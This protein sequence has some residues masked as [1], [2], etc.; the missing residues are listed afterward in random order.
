MPSVRINRA[1]T[2]L[3]MPVIPQAIIDERATAPD[4]KRLLVPVDVQALYVEEGSEDLFV[5][6]PFE[7]AGSGDRPPP[8]P[9]PF[10]AGERR[11]AGVHLRWVPPDALLRGEISEASGDEEELRLPLLPDRWVVLRILAPVGETKPALTGWVLEAESARAVPLAQWP[12]E[13]ARFEPQGRQVDSAEFD[14]TAGGSPAWTA[15]YDAA[16]NRFSFHDPLDDLDAVAPGGVTGGLAAYLVAGWY[17]DPAHDPLDPSRSPEPLYELLDELGWTVEEELGGIPRAQPP[18]SSLLHGQVHGVPVSGEAVADL[19][20]IPDGAGAELALAQDDVEAVAAL[21]ASGL[22]GE[23]DERRA[24]ERVLAA[25]VSG[26]LLRL[27]TPDGLVDIE[28]REHAAGFAARPG[29]SGPRER[30]LPA[31]EAGPLPAGR[32]ARSLAQD[33]AAAPELAGGERN[34][35]RPAPRFQQPIEPL[36]AVR[37]PK[38]SLIAHGDGRFSADGKLLCRWPSQVA[39]GSD[40]L[41]GEKLIGD[42]GASSIPEEVL[43]LARNVLIQDPFWTEWLAAAAAGGTPETTPHPLVDRLAAEAVL[44]FGPQGILDLSAL[45]N[46]KPGIEGVV[47]P[48][49]EADPVG[50][51]VWSQPWIPLFLEWE[52]EAA[53]EERFDEWPLGPLDREAPTG[54][55]AGKPRTFSGRSPI[56]SGPA[57][58]LADSVGAW[59]EEEMR[60]D[61]EGG[62]EAGDEDTARLGQVA[63]ALDVEHLDVVGARLDSLFEDLVGAAA[64]ERRVGA[65]GEVRLKRAR[66]L[67][68]FGR[69][70]E[71]PVEEVRVPVRAQGEGEGGLR[72]AP[73]LL[74]PS[75]WSFRFVD[76]ADLSGESR[77]ATV[78][79]VEEEKSVNPVAGFLLPD[80]LDESLEVFDTAGRPLGQLL[81]EPEG[82]GVV[83]EIAPGRPG[84][85]DAPPDHELE[86]PQKVLGDWA[87]ALVAADASERSG[88]PRAKGAESALGALLR[89]IDTT[90]WSVDVFGSFGNE[91]VSGLVGRPVAVVRAL[92]RLELS[93]PDALYPGSEPLTERETEAALGDRAFPV[94]VGELTR[95]DDGL[96]GF[97]VDDD[98]ESVRVVDRVV[99][100]SGEIDH[101]YVSA[102]DRLS[103]R[104]GQTVRLTLLMHPLGKV[105]LTSGILPRK[106]LRLAREWVN[107]G[108]AAMW[109]SVRVGP[110]LIGPDQVRLPKVASL[111]EDQLWTRRA[112]P[113]AWK[114]DPIVAATQAALLPGQPAA[115]EE[116]FIRVAPREEDRPG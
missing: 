61:E 62:G 80:H 40:E 59:V 69:T 42:L 68:A 48:V 55:R 109:P 98:Y 29:G 60:R 28:E 71:L 5:A 19:D 4:D 43:R 56:E 90:L 10:A 14:G 77:E 52:V 105:H 67:D 47:E 1:L 82:M 49:V 91:H 110:V 13:A 78:D 96:L 73:R 34:E 3:R 33:G 102:D 39:E 23:P 51:T 97:F 114:D 70:V 95:A 63:A 38:R 17:S 108:L 31:A 9:E 35:E 104:L 53:V 58:A 30:L 115:I 94:R 50:V 44:R 66:L 65:V 41:D 107:S 76:A 79:Q 18:R 36:V 45:P 64:G 6:L 8:Q 25:F 2:D 72:I 54:F 81:H 32:L 92:L 93:A 113:T 88:H 99:R 103:L 89:A 22:E 83:W 15:V 85:P 20:Q 57:R 84:P 101:P 21:A 24:L 111:P 46:V 74:H 116:G 112:S 26:L 106:S 16:R 12:A 100:E 7:L 87:G 37:G 11:P 75:R 27:D 86:P